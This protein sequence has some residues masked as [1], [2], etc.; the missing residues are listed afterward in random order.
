MLWGKV[1]HILPI[2]WTEYQCHINEP[3]S[4]VYKKN[5]DLESRVVWVADFV[6]LFIRQLRHFSHENLLTF[7]SFSSSSIKF[8]AALRVKFADFRTERATF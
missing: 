6:H 3:Y 4:F 8:N 7:S 5:V 1:G 2:I